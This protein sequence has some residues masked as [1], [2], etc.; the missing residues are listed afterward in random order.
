MVRRVGREN[1]VGQLLDCLGLREPARGGSVGRGESETEEGEDR[2]TRWALR[3]V[4][5]GSCRG[6]GGFYGGGR[7]LEAAGITM[8]VGR[9][10]WIDIRES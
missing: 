1:Y 2:R 3:G 7:R 10:S 8:R 4:G 9:S 5:C 6:G